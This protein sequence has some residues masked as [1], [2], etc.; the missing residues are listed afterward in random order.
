MRRSLFHAPWQCV[1]VLVCFLLTACATSAYLQKSESSKPRYTLAIFPWHISPHRKDESYRY[2]M[3]ALKDAL[4]TSDF[5]PVYSYYRFRRTPEIPQAMLPELKAIWDGVAF[6]PSVS[7]I[8]DSPE[9]P[10]DLGPNLEPAY[11]LGQQLDVDSIFIYAMDPHHGYDFMWVY[12]LDVRQRRTYVKDGV[13]IVYET[14][15]VFELEEMTRKVFANY[16]HDQPT[17]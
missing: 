16:I 8:R 3:W 1:S 5:L 13:V 9:H 11:R 12:L 14:D 2:G 17:K 4:K 7:G 10:S 6:P 15:G